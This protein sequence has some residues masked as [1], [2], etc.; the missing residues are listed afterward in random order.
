MPLTAQSLLTELD[1]T[2]Q[3]AS[4]PWRSTALRRIADLF[5]SGAD[6]YTADQVALF[7]AVMCRLIKNVDRAQLAEL[8]ARLAPVTNAPVK[9]L[10]A[11][12]RHSDL[13][14]CGPV[15]E[16]AQALPDQDLVEI[17]DKD[18]V[19]LKLLAKIAA[20]PQLGAAVTDV[21]LKRGDTA[22]QQMIVTNPDAQV[23]DSGFARLLVGMNG[24]KILA[25]AMAA[26]QDV[27]KEL[28]LWLAE[29]LSG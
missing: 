1:M 14:V 6:F 13:A 22:I 9:F 21:L 12:A 27:P 23:S 3:Q 28:R 25:A 5:L 17:A 16:Q 7:D 2:L 20:R 11:L 8:S 4:V 26:R 29:I 24:N 10:G 18:R 15:L 19:D